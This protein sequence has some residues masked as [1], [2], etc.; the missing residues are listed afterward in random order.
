MDSVLKKKEIL[1]GGFGSTRTTCMHLRIFLMNNFFL[2]PILGK[3]CIFWGKTFLEKNM[4]A[5]I[6]K[7]SFVFVC[8]LTFLKFDQ[9]IRFFAKKHFCAI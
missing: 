4:L 9:K 6:E 5:Q 8:A 7:F 1:M 2:K 3:L